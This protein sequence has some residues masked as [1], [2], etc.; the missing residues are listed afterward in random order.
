MRSEEI[1]RRAARILGPGRLYSLA[2]ASGW[3]WESDKDG[4][5]IRLGSTL[6]EAQRELTGSPERANQRGRH[7]DA[8]VH[9]CLRTGNLAVASPAS[10]FAATAHPSAQVGGLTH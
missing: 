10:Q 4:S 5:V 3:F 1:A 8:G 7:R 2:G 6:N 9:A